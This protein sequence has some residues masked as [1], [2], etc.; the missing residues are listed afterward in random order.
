MSLRK[1]K[2][3]LPTKLEPAKTVEEKSR[4]NLNMTQLSMSRFS[5]LRAVLNKKKTLK[6]KMAIIPNAVDLISYSLKC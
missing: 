6:E 1:R 5:A 3:K 4:A 2:N